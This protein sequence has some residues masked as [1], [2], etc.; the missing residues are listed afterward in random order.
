MGPPAAVPL[1]AVPRGDSSNLTA[2][3]V[4]PAG[5]SG[6]I[7]TVRCGI[8]ELVAVVRRRKV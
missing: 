7:W 8:I 3:V 5:A 4:S 1:T 2:F 6:P